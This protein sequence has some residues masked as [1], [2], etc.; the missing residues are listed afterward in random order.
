MRA[1]MAK[2]RDDILVCKQ[3]SSVPQC[4]NIVPLVVNLPTLSK[5]MPTKDVLPPRKKTTPTHCS[6]PRRD[7]RQQIG[8]VLLQRSM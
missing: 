6:L 1:E 5:A 4:A 2:M 3:T 7:P 8:N